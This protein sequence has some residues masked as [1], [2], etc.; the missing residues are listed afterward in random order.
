[1]S[2]DHLG[3]YALICNVEEVHKGLGGPVPCVLIHLRTQNISQA[4][5]HVLLHVTDLGLGGGGGG[6]GGC[7][8]STESPRTIP[9]W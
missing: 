1:M 8:V 5:V 9:A 7:V 6:G 3:L 2:V 4:Q